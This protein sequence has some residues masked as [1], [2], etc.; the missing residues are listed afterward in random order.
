QPEEPLACGR[1]K[2]A[3]RGRTEGPLRLGTY[4]PAPDG[5]LVVACIDVDG[6][7]EHSGPCADPKAAA[8]KI[9]AKLRRAGIVSHLE[10]STGG[11]GW[12][13]WIFFATPVSA[14]TVRRVLLPLIPADLPLEGGGFADP[15]K[16]RGVEV[17]PKRDDVNT[18]AGLVHMVYLPWWHGAAE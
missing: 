2:S 16:G 3:R 18:Q 12:P 10:R 11:K 7:S 17:F 4:S 9:Q 8:L 6:G 13:S 1:V 14:A 5:T 15:R